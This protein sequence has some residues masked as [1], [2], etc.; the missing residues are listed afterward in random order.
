MAKTWTSGKAQFNEH[1]LISSSIFETDPTK[2]CGFTL[3]PLNRI[4][5][6]FSGAKSIALVVN[7]AGAIENFRGPFIREMVK[8]GTKT[9]V[10]APDY[11]PAIE[12][13]VKGMGA[14]PIRYALDRTGTNPANELLT[15]ISL[16][17][18][19]RSLR[20][21]AVF[22]FQLKAIIYAGIATRLVAVPHRFGMIE[23]LGSY[24]TD[25]ADQMSAKQR[26]VRQAVVAALRPALAR[27]R[28]VFT[29][30]AGDTEFV[31]SLEV[32]HE[33]IIQLEGIGLDLDEWRLCPAWKRPVTFTFAGRFIR[34]KGVLDFVEAARDIG[35]ERAGVRFVI[36][37]GPD[38]NQS[39]V[40]QDVVEEWVKLGLVEW[41]G[42]VDVKP[43]F[44]Q[45][46]VFVLPSYYR[47]GKPRSTQ[48]AMAMGRPI[49]TTDVP[50][51]RETV[52]DGVNGFLVPPR[53]PVALAAA[54]QRFI[55]EPSLMAKM[56][57]ESRRMAE[58]KYDVHKVNKVMLDAMGL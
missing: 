41:P 25:S 5:K 49:I 34:H 14:C 50:G 23:G 32:P 42:F 47:E 11:T 35:R 45:T 33:R 51:C 28:K 38:S 48:E 37:G 13:A 55:D 7:T 17:K 26:F 57:A 2:V 18:A 16:Y 6:K 9:F 29:L 1:L 36:L 54:M 10:L 56:G 21:D 30:N 46:S 31:R 52:V 58:E 22:A 53:D 8:A 20:P 19:L 39:S 24:F 40:S 44:T 43:W 27:M 3:M 4:D 15:I 12:S